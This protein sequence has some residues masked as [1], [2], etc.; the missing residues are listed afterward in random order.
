[1]SWRLGGVRFEQILSE[2]PAAE[3]GLKDGDVLV[4]FDGRT[5]DNL[6]QFLAALEAKSP[7]DE[8]E[9]AVFRKGELIRTTVRLDTRVR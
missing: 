1:M 2:T 9:V 8:V 5:I 6:R 4:R 3:A 7:A